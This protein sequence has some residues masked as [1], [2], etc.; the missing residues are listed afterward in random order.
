[1][2]TSESVVVPAP[3]STVFPY[4]CD[5]AAYPSWLRLVHRADAADVPASAPPPTRAPPWYP[6]VTGC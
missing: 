4:V 2:R 1:M 3:P 6:G 5:L